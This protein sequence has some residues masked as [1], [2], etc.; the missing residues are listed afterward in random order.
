LSFVPGDV[1]DQHLVFSPVTPGAHIDVHASQVQMM[2]RSRCFQSSPAMTC[3]TCHDVH[4]AQR[5]LAAFAL[6]CQTCHQVERCRMF[7]KLGHG[8]DHQCI[9]CHLPLQ[10]TVQIISAVNGRSLQPKVRTHQIGI[11]PDS[12]LP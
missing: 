8:I 4:T 10:E 1:L 9:G 7:A 11:F 3:T 12:H 2:E 6:V 5:D